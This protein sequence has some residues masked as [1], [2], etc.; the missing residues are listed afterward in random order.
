[1]KANTV[2]INQSLPLAAVQSSHDEY[3]AIEIQRCEDLALA[4]VLTGD[5]KHNKNKWFF[6]T[7]RGTLM[8]VMVLGRYRT[9]KSAI[10][11]AG[12]AKTQ[13]RTA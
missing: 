10:E 5:L 1:M 2:F 11:A 9:L 12:I 3:F 13:A 6:N 7:T 4:D 8:H